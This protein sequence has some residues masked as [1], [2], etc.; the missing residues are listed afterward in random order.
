MSRMTHAAQID[1]RFGDSAREFLNPGVGF[2][3]GNFAR[4]RPHLF[5]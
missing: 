4:E 2:W 1:L 5:G 3:P